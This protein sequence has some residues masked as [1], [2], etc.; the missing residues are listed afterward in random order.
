MLNSRFGLNLV[1]CI[2]T[3]L[4]VERTFEEKKNRQ[5][6]VLVFDVRSSTAHSNIKL[7]VY[8]GGSQS[9]QEAIHHAVPVLGFPILSDQEFLL[10][11]LKSLGVGNHLNLEDLTTDTLKS[12]IL[13]IIRNKKYKRNMIEL[14]RLVNDTPYNLLDNLVW[15]TEYVIR[16]RGVPHLR[17]TLADQPWYQHVDMDIVAFLA[18]VAFI[19]FLVG[20]WISIKLLA[21]TCKQGQEAFTSRKRKTD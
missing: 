7:F 12:T 16:N 13:E 1:C 5:S 3:N 9:T 2:K 20:L 15:W 18:V 17:S 8:Q 10:K 14:R 19:V 4:S 21:Y 11:K 6:S